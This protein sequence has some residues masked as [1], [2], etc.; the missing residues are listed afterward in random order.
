MGEL[1][2][3]GRSRPL[4]EGDL[5]RYQQLQDIQSRHRVPLLHSA[6]HEHAYMYFALFDGTGQDKKDSGQHLTNIGRLA[7][8]VDDLE[9][10]GSNRIGG[11]YVEGIGTQSQP[12]KRAIDSAFAFSWD[13]KLEVAYRD[14]ADQMQEWR[15]IDPKAQ[16][17]IAAIG[18]SRGGVLA[19]GLLRLVDQYGISD[20]DDLKFGRDPHGNLTVESSRPPLVPPGQIPQIAGL[21]DPVATNMPRNYDARLNPR[22]LSAFSILAADEARK[23]FPHHTIVDPGLSSDGR[24]LN[25]HGAG[26]HANTGGGNADPLLETLAF[27]AMADYINTAFDSPVVRTLP[28]PAELTQATAHQV[29]G[30]TAGFGLRV[31]RD[32]RRDLHDTLANC[33][34][35]NPCEDAEP[36]DSAFAARFEWRT[37]QP[38]WQVPVL[39]VQMAA[40]PPSPDDPGHPDHARLQRIRAGVRAIDGQVG[41]PWDEASERLSRSLLAASKDGGDIA[42]VAPDG[43][44]ALT[45]VEHVALGTDG[46][47]AFAVQGGMQDPAHR[48]VGV[49]VDKALR[50]PIERSDARLEEANARI[51]EAQAQEAKPELAVERQHAPSLTR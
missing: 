6:H 8:Q 33:R 11:R 5:A 9:K 48:F 29:G 18:Y 41:K 26:G 30:V 22:V 35:V 20:P 24:L 46:R 43:A 34:I 39:S 37:V 38:G 40:H 47:Y 49:L 32:G 51:A 44:A 25:A 2:F 28:L 17:A 42:N 10:D 27:N 7:K 45:R 3:G 15:R 1:S 13:E 23:M 14:L 12:V 36:L 16:V 50:T 31:D 19:V 21:F 4:T